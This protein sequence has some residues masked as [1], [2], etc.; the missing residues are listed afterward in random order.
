MNKTPKKQQ[1]EFAEEKEKFQKQ[2]ES[3]PKEETDEVELLKEQVKREQE[4]Y[5]RALA[6]MEN[7]RKRTQKE[8][9]DT[10]RFAIENTLAEFLGPLDSF[11]NALSFACRSSEEIQTWAKGFEMILT[12]FRDV[13]ANYKVTPFQSEGSTFDPHLHEVIEMEE[14]EQYEE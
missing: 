6:D 2:E 11:E 12:Q 10:T 13:L 14:T 3:N 4:K 7:F 5:F 8:R 9:V 1:N